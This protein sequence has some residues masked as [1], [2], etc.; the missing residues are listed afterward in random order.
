MDKFLDAKYNQY[1]D[2]GAL[3]VA[4]IAAGFSVWLVAGVGLLKF[5]I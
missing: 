3:R 1:L 2:S 5:G 4:L